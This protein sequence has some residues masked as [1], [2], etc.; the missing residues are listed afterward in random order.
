MEKVSQFRIV[1]TVRTTQTVPTITMVSRKSVNECGKPT[2]K[3]QLNLTPSSLDI[4]TV[5]YEKC[6]SIQ[7]V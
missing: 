3:L 6:V 2:L 5:N 4:F 7:S 1:L